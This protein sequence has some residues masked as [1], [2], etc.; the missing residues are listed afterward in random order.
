MTKNLGGNKFLP[1]I[2]CF[3]SDYF[4]VWSVNDCVKTVL[5]LA[6]TY[7]VSY[8]LLRNFQMYY[9]Y[10]F[11]WFKLMFL[12]SLFTLNLQFTGLIFIFWVYSFCY[13]FTNQWYWSRFN[14]VICS[15]NINISLTLFWSPTFK[16]PITDFSTKFL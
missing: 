8:R 1:I 5:F 3:T 12:L 13:L 16:I 15:I 4:Q 11:N 10:I 7:A 6:L 14:P 2:P 9:L